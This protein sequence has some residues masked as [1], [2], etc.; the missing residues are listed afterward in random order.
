W[1]A[2]I[3]AAVPDRLVPAVRRSRG[4]ARICPWRGDHAR[5][6]MSAPEANESPPAV[7]GADSGI[8]DE[9]RSGYCL[10]GT[11]VGLGAGADLVSDLAAGDLLGVSPLDFCGKATVVLMRFST[12]SV[13]STTSSA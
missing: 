8:A 6:K 13:R 4:W 3:D 7:F 10:L 2:L 11:G 9:L 5:R 1:I 12:S